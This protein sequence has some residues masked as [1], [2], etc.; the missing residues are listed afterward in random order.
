MIII[1]LISG[2]Q[3]FTHSDFECRFAAGAQYSR[4]KHGVIYEPP[5]D[6]GANHLSGYREG[7]VTDSVTLLDRYQFLVHKSREALRDVRE[8]RPYLLSLTPAVGAQSSHDAAGI[9][10]TKMFIRQ[11]GV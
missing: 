10:T 11:V 6:H 9:R 7:T 2:Q 1:L 8:S 4:R 3:P 5:E